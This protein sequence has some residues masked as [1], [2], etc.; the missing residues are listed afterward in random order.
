[1]SEVIWIMHEYAINFSQLPYWYFHYLDQVY[2]KV[3]KENNIF[4]HLTLLKN[5]VE[6]RKYD[7][8]AWDG[9]TKHNSY[10]LKVCR[11]Y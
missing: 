9:I 5:M 6:L 2:H 1:M 3:L 10:L 4:E 11:I 8:I 7:K